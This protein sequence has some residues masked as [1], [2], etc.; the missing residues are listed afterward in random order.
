MNLTCPECKNQV[1][2]SNYHNLAVDNVVECDV[3]GVSLLV[4][5]ISGDNVKAEVVDEGK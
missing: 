1:D 4:T 5:E 3:C 2:L